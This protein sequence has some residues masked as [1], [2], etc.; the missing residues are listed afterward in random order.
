[1]NR[2]SDGTVREALRL[3]DDEGPSI[4]VTHGTVPFSQGRILSSSGTPWMRT[5]S[6]VGASEPMMFSSGFGGYLLVPT[7]LGIGRKEISKSFESLTY[8][9]LGD[10]ADRLIVALDEFQELRG[11]QY[12]IR[13]YPWTGADEEHISLIRVELRIPKVSGL[14]HRDLW[15]K[16]SRAFDAT[17]QEYL[18]EVGKTSKIG[19]QFRAISK[20]F[21]KGVVPM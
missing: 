20:S 13:A 9:V 4:R 12:G 16:Y 3:P 2:S 7:G 1:M 11:V 21:S 6:D 18:N 19:R 17:A 5:S 8:D 14:L 10:F 15:T